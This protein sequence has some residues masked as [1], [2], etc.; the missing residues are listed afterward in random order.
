VQAVTDGAEYGEVAGR[1]CEL[2]EDVLDVAGD[3]AVRDGQSAGDTP[4]GPVF[5]QHSE[6]LQLARGQTAE[7]AGRGDQ[8]DGSQVVGGRLAQSS[9]VTCR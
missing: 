9:T 8:D 6:D 4:V 1:G 5:Y 2:G 7:V 3:G